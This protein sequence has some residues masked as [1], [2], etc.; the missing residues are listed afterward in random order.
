M[1]KQGFFDKFLSLVAFRL[2]GPG[3]PG[4]FFQTVEEGSSFKN[5]QELH[6]IIMT[7]TRGRNYY[8]LLLYA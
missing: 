5:L 3:S 7:W 1:K 8:Y 2:S 6:D 4:L